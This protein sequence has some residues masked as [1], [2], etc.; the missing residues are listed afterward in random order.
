MLRKTIL[1]VVALVALV[2]VVP[3]SF[4]FARGVYLG[5]R[6]EFFWDYDYPRPGVDRTPLYLGWKVGQGH[7]SAMVEQELSQAAPEPN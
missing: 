7:F 2:F 6:G 1:W 5:G 3:P 4:E